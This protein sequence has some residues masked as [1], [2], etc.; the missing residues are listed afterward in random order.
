MNKDWLELLKEAFAYFM[1]N[2]SPVINGTK[3]Y[4][5]QE[6][7]FRAFKECALKDLKIVILGQDPYH[8]GKANGLC[9]DN[10]ML[11]GENEKKYIATSI[12]PSLSNILKEL[13]SD[14]ANSYLTDLF[15]RWY[16]NKSY[17]EHLPEQG[18]LMLNTA[19]TV[20]AQQAGSHTELWKP[21]TKLVIE[22]LNSKDDLV[23][24]LWGNHAKSFKQYIT[25]PT[26][27]FIEGGHPSPLNTSK[28]V[29]FKGGK[30][31]S[32]CNEILKSKNKTE[33]LW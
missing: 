5:E 8:D 31:F 19:L 7:I 2:I 10:E 27:V 16:T 32:R 3:F 30:Y 18:V 28:V 17:L 13:E 14:S 33:I 24:I 29:P 4:P 9:F 22:A 25:N 1:S 21:F 15:S 12:A 23:W 20:L 26:H 11:K 6:N